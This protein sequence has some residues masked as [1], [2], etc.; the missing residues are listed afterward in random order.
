VAVEA[1]DERAGDGE[2][3]RVRFDL[4][5]DGNGS[6]P[7]ASETLWAIPTGV[8]GHYRIDN[9][10]FFVV[11]VSLGDVVLAKAGERSLEFVGVVEKSGHRTLGLRYWSDQVRSALRTRLTELGCRVER[12][13]ARKVLAVDI[14]P[15]V[16]LDEVTAYL[17]RLEGLAELSYY[18]NDVGRRPTPPRPWRE[19]STPPFSEPPDLGVF[20]SRRAMT[21]EAVRV[22]DH[23]EDGDWIFLTG[24]ELREESGHIALDELSLV[25]LR[26]V[27]ASHPEVHACADLPPGHSAEYLESE[28]RWLWSALDPDE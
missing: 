9:V 16:S 20:V 19:P 21:G 2:Y 4:S 7:V 23:D 13:D 28:H 8:A 17:A 3:A 6:R 27:V 12:G 25:C 10:P 26:D 5:R 1:G 11:G 18:E 14:P 24:A 15:E 22:I